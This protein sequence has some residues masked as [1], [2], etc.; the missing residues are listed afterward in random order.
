MRELSVSIITTAKNSNSTIAHTVNSVLA[1]TYPEIEYIVVDG[2]STDGT[3]EII[4]SYGK[5]ISKFISEPDDGIYDAINKGIMAAGGDIIGILNSDDVFYDDNIIKRV[6]EE[7]RQNDIDS[8]IGDV[9]FVDPM[10][11][12][13]IL[14]YYSSR[15]FHPGKFKFGYMPAHPSFYAKRQLFEKYGLY[16]TDYEIAADYELLIRFMYK[17]KISYKYLGMPFVNMRTG[18]VST[19]SVRSNYILNKEI[20]RACRENGIRTNYFYIYSK[21]F[22]KVFELFGNTHSPTKIRFT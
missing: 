19:K 20:V 18:G 21:Y 14:R 15:N 6:A 1:Q 7:F 5:K 9:Q 2:F 17:N 16:K 4:K 8:V 10:N 22:I 13:K 11:I 12:K 3:I